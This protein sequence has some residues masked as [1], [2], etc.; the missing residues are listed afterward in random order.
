MKWIRVT[1]TDT[2]PLREGRC[3]RIGEEEIA[4][5][6]SGDNLSAVDN[7][8]PHLAV[9]LRRHRLRRTVTCP[10]TAYKIIGSYRHVVKPEVGR[11]G[12]RPTL[13]AWIDGVVLVI[14]EEKE[15]S[16]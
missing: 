2:I 13:C 7:A 9:R 16:A 6:Q 10:G 12:W 15:K 3:V 5:F 8:W 14:R 4:I 11:L 1:T